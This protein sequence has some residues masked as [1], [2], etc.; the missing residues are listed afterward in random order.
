[1]KRNNVSF[2][3]EDFNGFK[4]FIFD[5][6]APEDRVIAALA[7]LIPDNNI[8]GEPVTIGFND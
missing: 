8:A 3:A 1:M 7:T 2:E 6:D 5:S 4:D